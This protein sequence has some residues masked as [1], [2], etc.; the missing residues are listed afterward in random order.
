MGIARALRTRWRLAGRGILCAGALAATSAAAAPVNSYADGVASATA[1][2]TAVFSR[3][4]DLRNRSEWAYPTAS[5]PA[6]ARPSSIA[7][8][9]GR[10]RFLTTDDQAE[11]YVALA[12]AKLASGETWIQ[13][14][15]PGRPNGQTGWVPSAALG[16]LHVVRGF[17]LIN[18]TTLRA[19][20]FRDGRAIIKVPIGVGKAS[21]PTP[22]GHF[23]V[24]EK[25]TSLGDPFYGP[26]AIGTSAYAPTL[27]E[28]PGGGVV[29]IHGTSE[30]Q[31]IPGR[32]SHGCIRMRNG[33]VTRVWRVISLGTP[34][35][36][37]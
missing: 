34:I 9:V 12:S 16:P 20:L 19:T 3:L 31:L 10:L 22:A 2:P 25:L 13:V 7:R 15:L 1:P 4:S 11:L 8:V 21:T 37:V 30:P 14:E 6:R 33:D 5:A 26:L 23:Y 17:L 27:S 32:P 18:R 29:G 24:L 35:E 28:W 36:I